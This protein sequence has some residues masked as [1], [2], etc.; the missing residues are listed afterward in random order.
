MAHEPAELTEAD[1]IQMAFP[2]E[3][4]W[5]TVPDSVL[6]ELVQKF[7]YEQSC[8]GHGIGQLWI[9]RHP[10][11]R[12]LAKWLLQQVKADKHLKAMATDVLEDS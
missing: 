2:D 9:R 5:D 12:E 7:E 3:P 10:L 11:A 6:I 1:W 4:D 8:A